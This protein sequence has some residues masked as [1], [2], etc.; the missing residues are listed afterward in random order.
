MILHVLWILLVSS[1]P[2][3]QST[4]HA[5][6]R[7]ADELN[8]YDNPEADFAGPPGNRLDNVGRSGVVEKEP[9]GDGLAVVRV[10]G[11]IQPKPFDPNLVVRSEGNGVN[12]AT[13]ETS[14][15]YVRHIPIRQNMEGFFW[16]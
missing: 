2:F 13:G 11:Y 3:A 5:W 10:V 16:E 1:A 4:G 12:E 15:S 7:L 6:G 14:T 8:N 9:N